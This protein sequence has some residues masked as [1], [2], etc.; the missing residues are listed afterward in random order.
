M[1]KRK[2]TKQV[3]VGNVKVGGGALVSVQSMTKEKTTNAIIK[4]IKELESLGCD[5]VRIA[6]PDFKAAREVKTIKPKV[7]IPIIA[8]IHFN[9]RL[10]IEAIKSGADKVRINP[11]NIGSK[12][13]VKE[14]V[15]CARDSG[16]PIRIGVNS[17]SLE[18]ELLAKYGS[19]KP[20][21]LVES[22][23]RWVNYIESLDFDQLVLSLKSSDTYTTIEAYRQISQELNYPLHIGVT[24]T[25]TG[26]SGMVRSC[27]G[28]GSLLTEGIGDTLRVS[29]TGPARDEVKLGHEILKALHLKD[30]VP[31]IIA[32]PT[33]GRCEIDVAA[34]VNKVEKGLNGIKK[35]LQIAIMGCVVNGPGEARDA[36]FGIT[37]RKDEVFIF[38]KGEIIKTVPEN[39]AVA[40]LL[41][42]IFH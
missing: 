19:P 12:N 35:P 31:Q 4:E 10:A 27:I 9:Y 8:D 13:K 41:E 22:I 5:L 20:E 33:C 21:A 3:T 28:I 30:A 2:L 15:K 17:G 24:A 14:V 25:G 6:I 11:G 40:A 34:L 18:K 26:I 39:K 29:L 16:I 37:G 38:K 23:K 42:E 7:S 32:C 1:I 36:D